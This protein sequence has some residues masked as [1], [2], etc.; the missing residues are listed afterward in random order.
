MSDI[1]RESYQDP[2]HQIIWQEGI[3]TDDDCLPKVRVAGDGARRLLIL[4]LENMVGGFDNKK[5]FDLGCGTGTLMLEILKRGGN[6]TGIE[7][8]STMLDGARE[9]L[10]ELIKGA[11]LDQNTNLVDK[12]TFE[13]SEIKDSR[14]KPSSFDVAIDSGVEIHNSPEEHL[15]NL[16]KTREILKIN[17]ITASGFYS[18][19]GIDPD[20]I[21]F[22]KNP[23]L[24]LFARWNKLEEEFMGS[25]STKVVEDYVPATGDNFLSE[26]WIPQRELVHKMYDAAR[27]KIVQ[28]CFALIPQ[29]IIDV[30]SKWAN[31]PNNIPYFYQVFAKKI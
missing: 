18:E 28:E 1:T 14:Q 26:I 24:K 19:R 13:L 27:L 25:K 8:S 10:R 12:V 15:A 9:Q 5:I 2:N 6:V 17:G 31:T 21:L 7:R 20:S 30:S 29:N 3:Q 23:D 4:R 11:N 16:R 22:T